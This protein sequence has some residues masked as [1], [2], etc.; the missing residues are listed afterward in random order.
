[1]FGWFNKHRRNIAR[2]LSELTESRREIVHAFEIERRRIER[3]LHDGAQ[4]FVVATGMA[5]GEAELIIQLAG[6]LPPALADLPAVLARAQQA[7]AEGLAAIRATV[8]NV[9]PKVLSDLG[10]EKAI[11]DVA[12]RAEIPVQVRVPHSLPTMPEGIIATGYFLVSEALTNAAK[13]APQATATVVL[14][15]DDD[16]HI[17]IVDTGLGG[18][19]ITPGHGLAGL[20]E[21]L[22][23]FGGKLELSSPAG[24]PTV[25]RATIPLLLRRGESG[26]PNA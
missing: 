8:N 5:L 1:M 22:A 26:V 24:G 2:E 15:A 7:N 12:E 25:L 13:H 21:R 4:Q 10:L 23:A 19:T 9:H 17:S 11:R 14:A 18:A 3:D 16:L 20:R 6:T